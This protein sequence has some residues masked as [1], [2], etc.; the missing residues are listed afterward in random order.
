MYYVVHI[1]TIKDMHFT[2]LFI[3]AT[4]AHSYQFI[5][6]YIYKRM[7]IYNNYVCNINNRYERIIVVETI[8]CI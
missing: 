5:Y 8:S 1:I 3:Y 6:G 4:Y 2:L 7:F